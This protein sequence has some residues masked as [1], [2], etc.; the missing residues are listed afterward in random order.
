LLFDD[1]MNLDN[2]GSDGFL[3]KKSENS[4]NN[5]EGKLDFYPR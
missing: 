4:Q 3:Q 2:L 5:L 1:D